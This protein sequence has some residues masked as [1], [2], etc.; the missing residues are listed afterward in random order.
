MVANPQDRLLPWAAVR[1]KCG[2]ISRTTVWRAV[3]RKEFPA[4][5]RISPN[6]VGWRES[7]LDAWLANR[8]QVVSQ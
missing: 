7:D 1:A 6:R 2:N 8:P 3:R 5:V 4:S